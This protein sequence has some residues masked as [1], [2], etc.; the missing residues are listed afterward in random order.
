LNNWLYFYESE[1]IETA[2]P[3]GVEDEAYLLQADLAAVENVK[4]KHPNVDFPLKGKMKKIL[5]GQFFVFDARMYLHGGGP[6]KSTII[7]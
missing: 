2:K 6:G 3:K 7:N 1:I 5:H 4:K